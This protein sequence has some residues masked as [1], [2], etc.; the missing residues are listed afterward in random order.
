MRVLFWM[1][2]KAILGSVCLL[3]GVAA[4]NDSVSLL[5]WNVRNYRG[6]ESSSAA[7][8]IGGAKRPSSSDVVH[9]MVLEHW[10]DLLVIAEM[11][12]VEDLDHLQRLLKEAGLDLPY[13][14]YVNGP[15]PDRHLALL[16][17]Y[18][19]VSF[20]EPDIRFEIDGRVERVQRGVLDVQV[21]TSGN[22][23]R[24]LGAHLKSRL[25]VKDGK[26]QEIRRYESH[27]LRQRMESIAHAFPSIPIILVGDLNET[28]DKPGVR[29][30]SANENGFSLQWLDIKDVVGDSWTYCNEQSEVYERI[31]FVG[32][33][34]R[35]PWKVDRSR[36]KI[37]RDRDLSRGSDHRPL[38]VTFEMR[39]K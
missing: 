38:L 35:F 33:S 14:E 19:V 25:E 23:F 8:G 26:E 17:R 29:E 28:K 11:G 27:L 4:A 32:V 1:V 39:K 10:P 22:T 13:S 15:D 37:L 21:E 12:G 24:L 20:S 3:G 36:S 16:S 31:D 34:N 30:L 6:V 9:R 7:Q 2:S 5:F 18:K